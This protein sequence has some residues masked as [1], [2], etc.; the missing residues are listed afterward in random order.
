MIKKVSALSIK[1][2]VCFCAFNISVNAQQ[3]S[4]PYKNPNLSV[5]ERV[6][7]LLKRMT[8]DEKIAQMTMT[9]LAGYKNMTNGAGVC[10][11]PFESIYTVAQN[12]A[13][14]KSMHVKIHV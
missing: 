14:S 4:L 10:D 8:L 2:L 6:N 13:R 1:M 12:S 9:N 7:D 11:S 3:I 5:E